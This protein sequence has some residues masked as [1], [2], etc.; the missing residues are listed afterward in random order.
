MN[1]LVRLTDLA[2]HR[3]YTYVLKKLLGPFLEDELVLG[4][5]VGRLE[6]GDMMSK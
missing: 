4:V 5:S 1:F 3:L 6:R 2:L